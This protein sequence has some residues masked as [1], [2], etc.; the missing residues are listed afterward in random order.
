M[1]LLAGQAHLVELDGKSRSLAS[2]QMTLLVGPRTDSM[3]FFCRSLASNQMTLL[4]AMEAGV[5]IKKSRSLASNQMTLLDFGPKLSAI[6]IW[7]QSCLK[8]DDSLG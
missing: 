5:T 4:V 1:T 6:S 8:S 7:S 2:N 3:K